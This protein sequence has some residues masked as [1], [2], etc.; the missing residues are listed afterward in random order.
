MLGALGLLQR[1][2]EVLC[3]LGLLQRWFEVLGALELFQ[4]RAT[5]VR[6]LPGTPGRSA[7]MPAR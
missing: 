3:A 7:S 2:F 1:W 4:G 6:R 5:G